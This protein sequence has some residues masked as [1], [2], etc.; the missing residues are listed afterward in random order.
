MTWSS[1]GMVGS[2][3]R[4]V[5]G[6]RNAQHRSLRVCTTTYVVIRLHPSGLSDMHRSCR[7]GPGPILLA[8]AWKAS[9]P[10]WGRQR[11]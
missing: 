10:W 7:Y 2:T 8:P 6:W 3:R 9:V 1:R 5:P 11:A 4:R